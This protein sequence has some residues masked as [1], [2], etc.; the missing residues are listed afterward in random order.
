LTLSFI[1]TWRNVWPFLVYG[2]IL[3]ILCIVAAIPLFLGFL[4]VGPVIA[5]SVYASYKDIFL[6]DTTIP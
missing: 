4:V 5:A 6:H 3:L 2:L 1:G